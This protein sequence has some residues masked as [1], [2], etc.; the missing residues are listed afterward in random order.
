M[1]KGWNLE[2]EAEETEFIQQSSP[3]L[4][5]N[6]NTYSRSAFHINQLWGTKSAC[7]L[8]LQSLTVA[9]QVTEEL[10]V[11]TN[12]NAYTEIVVSFRNEVLKQTQMWLVIA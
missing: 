12:N 7:S 3:E 4:N 2:T 8:K 10:C 6:W 5:F 11:L 1:I 9:K